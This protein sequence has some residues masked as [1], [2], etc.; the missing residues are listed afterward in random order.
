MYLLD[1]DFLFSYFFEEQSTHHKAKLI[2]SKIE[3]YDLFVT[4]IVLHELATVL[5]NKQSQAQS[6][7][8][9][10]KCKLLDLNVIKMTDVQEAE[11]WKLFDLIDKDKTSFIDCSNLYLAKQLDYKIASFDKF[12][13][14]NTIIKP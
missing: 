11:V 6:K 14:D 3:D 9:I 4:N 2:M 5:S 7:I 10:Q 8:A 13:P 1:T 12:Y